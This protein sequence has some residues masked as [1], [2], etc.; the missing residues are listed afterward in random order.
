MSSLQWLAERQLARAGTAMAGM[1]IG[2]YRDLAV[3]CAPDGAEAWANQDLLAT[4]ASIG[5][6]PDPLGPDGQVWSLPPPLPHALTASG[7][8][9]F[10]ALLAA[11]MAHA[12]ALRIDHAMA[13]SRL[14]WVPDGGTGRDGAYVGY[15]FKDLLGEVTLASAEAQC[16]VVGEDLGTVPEGLP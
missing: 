8:R 3:G 12:G 7:Y 16:A 15:P 4:G 14:F 1:E 9:S 10:A 6:P 13:L 11:N 2:L 5:A